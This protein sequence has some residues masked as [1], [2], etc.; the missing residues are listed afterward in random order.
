[1]KAI[2]VRVAREGDE[3]AMAAVYVAAARQAWAHIYGEANLDAMEPPVAFFRDE[4]T[5][6]DSRQQALVAEN[7]SA[8]VAFAVIRPSRDEDADEDTVGEL[9]TIYSLPSVW[10][11]GV[12]RTLMAAALDALREA[13]FTEATLWTAE[14]NHRPR[15]IYEAAGWRS[16]GLSRERT[17]RG[18]SF[19]E[20][21]YRIA[22]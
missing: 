9:D 14:E 12:G 1:M 19:R 3:E 5:H 13:G 10:G 4:I 6:D 2:N 18:V 20:L 7:V 22:L 11:R 17:W 21:R 15:R 8:V 16:D